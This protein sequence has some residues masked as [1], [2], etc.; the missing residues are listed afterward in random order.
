M[1]STAV[2]KELSGGSDIL[3]T[4]VKHQDKVSLSDMQF[5]TLV[6]TNQLFKLN[7]PDLAIQRRLYILPF[8]QVISRELEKKGFAEL[9]EK[10]SLPTILKWAVD[11][12]LMYIGNGGLIHNDQTSALAR[13]AMVDIDVYS[14][15]MESCLEFHEHHDNFHI[16][17]AVW[18]KERPEW[19]IEA[20]TLRQHFKAWWYDNDYK[21]KDFPSANALTRRFLS[22]GMR[23][24]KKPLWVNSKT[25]RYWLG[26][27]FKPGAKLY[28]IQGTA[29]QT[30]A[31]NN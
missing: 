27:K 15:F 31:S 16:D 23:K 22:L 6:A 21:E 13:E 18:T 29:F 20:T 9:L 2:I 10:Y 17:E 12:Y 24:P 3:E 25:G 30:R 4:E 14:E 26:V 11:G 28:T 1:V 8:D 19:C 5:V 7:E